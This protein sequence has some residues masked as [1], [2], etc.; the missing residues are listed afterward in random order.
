[1][2]KKK[3]VNLG[4]AKHQ[5]LEESEL[6][7]ALDELCKD[8]GLRYIARLHGV[9][10]GNLC[11]TLKSQ[12]NISNKIANIAGFERKIIFVKKVD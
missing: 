4:G 2:K 9:N 10:P 7:L 5:Y 8:Q 3:Y 6:R 1:M 11:T 12:R